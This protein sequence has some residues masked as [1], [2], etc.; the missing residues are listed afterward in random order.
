MQLVSICAITPEN[1]TYCI[2]INHRLGYETW[3][4]LRYPLPLH[5]ILQQ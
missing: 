3:I 1:I 5:I 4:I 2:L